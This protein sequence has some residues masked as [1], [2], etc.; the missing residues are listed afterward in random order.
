M[1]CSRVLIVDNGEEVAEDTPEN[2]MRQLRG[3]EAIQV[4]CVDRVPP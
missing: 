1:V 2:L 4:R 3:S